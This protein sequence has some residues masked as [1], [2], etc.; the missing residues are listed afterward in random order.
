MF[1]VAALYQFTR[2]DDP[3]GLREPLRE[4]CESMAVRG[5]LLLAP[6]GINGTIAGP[7]KGIEAV[8]A[9]IRTLPGCGAVEWKESSAGAMPFNRLRVR[10]PSE[11]DWGL[12]SGL[13][14]Q[15]TSK[16]TSLGVADVA[17]RRPYRAHLC[18]VR[19]H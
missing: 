15:A 2:F 5:T 7:R 1:T 12:I 9:H 17:Q 18:L 6:E 4:I 19:G 11:D 16:P 8:I 3:D 10:L 14:A 13:Y